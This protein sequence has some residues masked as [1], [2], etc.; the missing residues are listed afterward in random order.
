MITLGGVPA[1]LAVSP[2]QWDKYGESPI[3]LRFR[4][5]SSL[6]REAF[7]DLCRDTGDGVAIPVPIATDLPEEEVV[8]VMIQD[9]DRMRAKPEEVRERRDAPPVEDDFGDEDDQ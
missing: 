5:G 1:V 4:A 6:A 2:H 7:G 9:L 8:Q 3:W